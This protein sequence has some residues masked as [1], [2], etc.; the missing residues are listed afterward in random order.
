MRDDRSTRWNVG[1]S[2]LV[3]V[4]LLGSAAPAISRAVVQYARDADKVDGRHAVGPRASSTRRAGKLVATNRKGLL[5]NNIIR[6]APDS[7]ALGGM[8]ADR[9]TTECDPGSVAGV[10]A[11]EAPANLSAE[12]TSINGYMFVHTIGGAPPGVDRCELAPLQARRVTTG[13]YDIDV[14]EEPPVCFTQYLPAVITPHAGSP[15]YAT[16]ETVCDEGVVIRVSLWDHDG[17]PIEV[18]FDVAVLQPV[19]IGLP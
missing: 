8:S 16:H 11:V 13:V 10:A 3:V 9:Y 17:N 7:R 19:V 15:V 1:L 18:P 2:M 12:W 4:L 5:P 14:G 6:K